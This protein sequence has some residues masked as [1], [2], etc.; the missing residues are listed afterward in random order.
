MCAH[1][2]GEGQ[3]VLHLDLQ[4]M[5]LSAYTEALA[6]AEF[7]VIYISE[8][9]LWPCKLNTINSSVLFMKSL[10]KTEIATES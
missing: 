8:F 3:G 5:R 6:H 1:G 4:I 2:V 9:S 7:C 10:T